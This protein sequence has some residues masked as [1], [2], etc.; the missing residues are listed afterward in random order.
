MKVFGEEAEARLGAHVLLPLLG[1]CRGL[2]GTPGA[3]L[4]LW[5]TVTFMFLESK[6]PHFLLG[7]EPALG[8]WEWRKP[9][10][11]LHPSSCPFSSASLF[12]QVHVQC[13]TEPPPLW[14]WLV[15]SWS[16]QIEPSPKG[17]L[18][19]LGPAVLP[20]AIVSKPFFPKDRGFLVCSLS[21]S[22]LGGT[23]MT[24]GCVLPLS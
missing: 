1:V 7:C 23:G 8:G 10:H 22:S 12:T 3:W 14:G 11:L 20:L 24:K 9:G 4:Q 18:T 17:P 13:L 21:R 2:P 5:Q 15:A 6:M 16:L 19:H